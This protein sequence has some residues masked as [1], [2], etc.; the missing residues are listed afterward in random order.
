LTRE[1]G[2]FGFKEQDA[3]TRRQMEEGPS[4]RRM[5]EADKVAPR[6]AMLHGDE[7]TL[8]VNTPELVQDGLESDAVFVSGPQLN[9]AVRERRGDLA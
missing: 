7:G 4:R 2:E 3:H 9:D 8:P 6:V 5:H 1:G